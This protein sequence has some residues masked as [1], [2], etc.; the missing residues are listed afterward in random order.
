MTVHFTEE[1]NRLWDMIKPWL[2]GCTLRKD[3]PKEIV[4][5]YK[6]YDRLFDEQYEFEFNLMYG[7]M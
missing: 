4:E 2:D 7:N 6:E 1:M 3:A 5:A